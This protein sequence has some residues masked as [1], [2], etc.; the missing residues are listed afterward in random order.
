[1]KQLL[2]LL[3][4]LT[5]VVCYGQ[6]GVRV[7]FEKPNQLYKQTLVFLNDTTNDYFDSCCDATRLGGAPDGIWTEIGGTQYAINSYGNFDEFED[8]IIPL[9]T[10]A[11]YDTGVS[12]IGVDWELNDMLFYGL[13]DNQSPGIHQLPYTC[14]GPINGQRFSLYLEYQLHVEVNNSCELGYVVIQN[15]DPE[16]LYYLMN[17]SNQVSYLPNYTDTIFDLPSGDYTLCVYDN[18]VETTEFTINNTVIDAALYIPQSTVY[19]GDSYV[20]PFINI[21]SPY[22]NIS[23]DFGDG[24]VINSY[25]DINPIHYYVEPGVYVLKAI[26][27]EGQCSKVFEGTINVEGSLGIQTISRP[28]YRQVSDYIYSIDGKLIKKL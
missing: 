25:N 23:W 2:V 16:T 18:I 1:M 17:D 7:Y 5:N 22:T 13:L 3:Y 24:T 9:Y 10:S 26:I 11:Y 14:E 15:D 19:I 4:L 12:I 6:Y 8:K 21:Y 27:N 20:T 28:Q